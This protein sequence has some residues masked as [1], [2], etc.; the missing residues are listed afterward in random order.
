MYYKNFTSV[1]SDLIS[2]GSDISVNEIM[3]KVESE[4]I[5]LDLQFDSIYGV[6]EIEYI[7]NLKM[8]FLFI[9]DDS[10]Y[11]RRFEKT[12]KIFDYCKRKIDNE[13]YHYFF[14]TFLDVKISKICVEKILDILESYY[15]DN[16]LLR[17]KRKLV[18]FE[19]FLNAEGIR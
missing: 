14:Y 6:D 5:K 11:S 13:R 1:H 15:A 19:K 2:D 18:D 3:E 4:L 12:R 8:I 16:F 17:F 9:L 10:L 7:T